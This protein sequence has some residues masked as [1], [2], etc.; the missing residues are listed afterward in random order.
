METYRVECVSRTAG[1]SVYVHLKEGVQVVKPGG[2]GSGPVLWIHVLRT[3][4][5]KGAGLIL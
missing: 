1:P 4:C 5:K 2:E 3:K